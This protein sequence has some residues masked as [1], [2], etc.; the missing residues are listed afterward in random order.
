MM[1][2][3]HRAVFSWCGVF[4]LSISGIACGGGEEYPSWTTSSGLQVTQIAEGEGEFPQVGDVVGVVYKASYVDGE[5][6]DA[7]Q[8]REEPFRFRLGMHQALKGLDEGVSTMRPGGKRILVLPPNLA[9]EA[10][11]DERPSTVP[12]N[13]WVR[14]EVELIDIIE[15]PPPPEPWSDIGY[16]IA[17]LESGL[18]YVD[19]EIGEGK[20][21]EPG[22]TIVVHYSGFL[23]DG[24]VFDTTTFRG[25][26]IAFTFGEAHLLTGWLQGLAT[27][28]EGGKRKL[29]VPPHLAYGE[30]GF[31][32][33]IPPNATLT[34]DIQLLSVEEGEVD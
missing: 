12:E 1:I 23:D 11:Q 24:T 16:D 17:V 22:N 9:F 26:P 19:F 5:Q 3:F 14:F 33:A 28:K 6:F 15:A 10:T 32:K 31:R 25:V 30:K 27:M 4:A 29:I 2:S 13:A 34:F 18:Q 21:P 7:Y 20:S 8:E